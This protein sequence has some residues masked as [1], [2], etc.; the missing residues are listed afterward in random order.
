[1]LTLCCLILFQLTFF[2]TTILYDMRPDGV[3]G[4]DF[5]NVGLM[6]HYSRFKRTARKFGAKVAVRMSPV[7]TACSTHTG[8]HVPCLLEFYDKSRADHALGMLEV[9]SMPD[10]KPSK[11]SEKGSVFEAVEI[12]LPLVP[13]FIDHDP[14][15]GNGQGDKNI[16]P[17]SSDIGND[18]C[19]VYGAGIQNDSAFESIMA[20]SGHSTF[21]FDCSLTMNAPS[22]SGKMFTFNPWCIGT[23]QDVTYESN[24]INF[25][26]HASA[27]DFRSLVEAMGALGHDHIDLLKFD[28]EGFEWEMIQQQLL[29]S[30]VRPW[31]LAFELHA[32]HA[33]SAAVPP[34]LVQ[35]KGYAAVNRLFL[36]LYKLGY[37]VISKEIN[38][39]DH[40]CAEFV[41]VYVNS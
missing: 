31:Q 33:D 38:E 23:P 6:E 8:C 15:E 18:R 41:L 40:A 25:Q 17:M 14:R 21:A 20:R 16:V 9:G 29:R 28:I 37:R 22:V 39:Y 24:D 1:M 35:G 19:L 13:P 36:E 7:P 12:A 2:C 34:S 26:G 27:L 4:K 10:A 3:L 11:P 32:E 5:F 30:S